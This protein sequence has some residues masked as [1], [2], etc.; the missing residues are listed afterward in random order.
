MG[1]ASE[2]S[3][4]VTEE[5]A[6]QQLMRKGGAIDLDERL[7][8]VGTQEVNDRGEMIFACTTLAANENRGRSACNFRRLFQQTLRYGIFCDKT[9]KN[10][11]R[12]T[13]FQIVPYLIRPMPHTCPMWV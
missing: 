13:P 12:M 11:R 10:A 9:I 6:F 4:L 5:F 2:R 8:P 7:V 1:R 3:T